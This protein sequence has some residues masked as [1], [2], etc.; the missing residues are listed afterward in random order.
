M[1]LGRL[2]AG[3]LLA[4]GGLLPAAETPAGRPALPVDEWLPPGTPPP[5]G[6]TN[7]APELFQ[8]LQ[9]EAVAGKIKITWTPPLADT[10]QQ[11]RLWASIDEP[12]HWQARHWRSYPMFFRGHCWDV[13]LP[14]LHVDLPLVYFVGERGDGKALRVSPLRVCRPRAA[15]LE[16]PSKFFWP[17]LEGFEEGLENW[18]LWGSPASQP[19]LAIQPQ[20]RQGYGALRVVLPPGRDRVA[21]GSTVLRGWHLT[22]FDARG[23]RLWMR[24]TA[25]H[26]QAALSV[27][28]N[29]SQTNQVVQPLGAS[30]D[31]GSEWRKFEILFEL[32]PAFPRA[33]L[34]LLVIEFRSVEPREFLLDE[35]SLLGRWRLELD[36]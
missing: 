18:R 8:F 2:M 34:D 30:F 15:G 1:R 22:H 19:P 14:I 12:G 33:D 17:Y 6:F 23:L 21:V 7:A 32:P 31:L 9:A 3:M 24:T 10:N 25:G 11:P 20:P 5:A 27:V 29:A 4:L 35:I 16:E 26:G 13:A 28:A 36:R